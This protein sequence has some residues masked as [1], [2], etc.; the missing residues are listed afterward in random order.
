M[1]FDAVRAEHEYVT[2]QTSYRK[3][4]EKYE[5]DQATVC[6][7]AKQGGWVEKR[8]KFQ[9]EVKQK[10]NNIS[11]DK[12]VDKLGTLK[13]ATD[14]AIEIVYGFIEEF[15]AEADKVD[16]HRNM[17]DCVL[18]LKEL[19]GLQRNLNGILTAQEEI[20]LRHTDENGS[21]GGVIY[22]PAVTEV[23]EEAVVV[24]E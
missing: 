16:K 12:E 17:K 21:E 5:V 8:K 18:M 15:A 19:A 20:T 4:A 2:T 6:K 22:I 1:K 10:L 13:T 7:Y 11:V 23:D 3:L 14:T 24:N 9:A